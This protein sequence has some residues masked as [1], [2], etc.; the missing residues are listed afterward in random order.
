MLPAWAKRMGEVVR[1]VW[2]E[3]LEGR[4]FTLLV[5]LGSDGR[6]LA[7]LEL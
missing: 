3:E 2:I 1:V 6:F 4:I 7:V 5:L